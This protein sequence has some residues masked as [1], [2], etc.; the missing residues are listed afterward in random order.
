MYLVQVLV[1]CESVMLL[2][3]GNIGSSAIAP[4]V[5]VMFDTAEIMPFRFF[6]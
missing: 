3:E 4:V 6:S 2:G 1:I 5:A